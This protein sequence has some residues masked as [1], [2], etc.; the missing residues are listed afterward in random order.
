MATPAL[1]QQW[2]LGLD[3][4]NIQKTIDWDKVA[5]S[6]RKWVAIK[7]TEGAT[8]HDPYFQANMR[9]AKAAGL[10]RQPYCFA[11]FATSTP[12]DEVDSFVKAVE[13]VAKWDELIPAFLDLED[14]AGLE[15]A[16][17]ADRIERWFERFKQNTGQEGVLYTYPAFVAEHLKGQD[18]SHHPLLIAH[19][20]VDKP[21]IPAPWKS[22]WG[23]QYTSDGNLPGISGRVDLDVYCGT[24]ASLQ[25]LVGKG[26][27]TTNQASA[28]KISGHRTL[29]SGATG[30][31]VK[32]CQ[33]LFYR[34]G[35]HPGA[36][37][38][39]YGPNT[40]AAVKAFQEEA[41]IDV[42]GI[43]GPDTWNHLQ[44][45]RQASRP[46]TTSGDKGQQVTDLQYLLAYYGHSPGNVDGVFGP[47][48]EA[49]VKDF[50]RAKKLT[51]DGKV[52]PQTWGALLAV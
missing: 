28:P 6:G 34:A 4:S 25:A 18:L 47:K 35:Q 2:V 10:L 39:A 31:D 26:A 45:A 46:L 30:S 12:E 50:Q 36:I 33:R 20:G 42:D 11:R 49:A 32:L 13:A 29:Y 22:I 23:W 52:G 43:C 24:L 1:D 16:A 3:V 7:V 21:T 40:I 17:L 38:G 15:P 9:G 8:F 5:T 44:K 37:D 27:A 41:K 19:Y 51:V 14:A 48:T